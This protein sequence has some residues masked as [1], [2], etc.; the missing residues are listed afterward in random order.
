MKKRRVL[1]LWKAL[2]LVFS[3]LVG[4]AGVTVLSLYLMGNFNNEIIEPGSIEFVK[5]LS[6]GE[7]YYNDSLKQ[8]EVSSDFKMTITTPTENVTE[9][10]IM[11]SLKNNI[12]TKDGYISDGIIKVPQEVY[13]NKPFTVSLVKNDDV[14][15]EEWVV[16]GISTLT[17]KSTDVLSDSK[18]E[19][20][21]VDV[22]VSDINLFIG[23]TDTKEVVINDKFKID[24]QFMPESSKYLFSDNLRTQE[25][26]QQR[27]KEIFYDFTSSYIDYN[28]TEECFEAKTKSGNNF[29]EI[30][31]YTFSNSY[32]QTQIMQMFS[33]ITDREDLTQAVLE[34]FKTHE[35]ARVSKS[36][37]VQ[38]VDV[39]VSLVEMGE[40]GKTFNTYLDQYLTITTASTNGDKSL[41]LAIK[42]K[43][44]SSLPTLLA[45]VGIKI[46]Q[47]E[48]LNIS[49]GKIVEVVGDAITIK[50]FDKT[51][52]YF[53]APS[54]TEYYLLP[55][56]T[57]VSV[58]DY[59]WKLAAEKEQVFEF[60]V[61]LFCENKEGKLVKFFDGIAKQEPKFY[62]NA[63]MH[64]D[65][66]PPTWIN[67]NETLF[68]T[69]NYY[70]NGAPK[71]D[72]AELY[73]YLNAIKSSNIYQTVKYFL[74]VNESDVEA[75]FDIQTYFLCKNGVE[76]S[77]LTIS[78]A[79]A[80]GDGKYVLYEIED[81]ILSAK[82]SF[83]GK[84]KVIAAT[85]KT[86]A[87]KITPYIVDEKYVIVQSTNWAKEV[88]VESSLS[89]ANMEPTFAVTGIV[90]N[91]DGEYYIPAINR[92]EFGD[93]KTVITFGL[94]LNNCENLSVDQNKV[95]EAYD[96]GNLDIICVDKAGEEIADY[97]T[98]Q[99]LAVVEA[100]GQTVTL[101]GN[102]AIEE[103]YFSAGNNKVDEGI[104]ISLR[105]KY[106]DGN[107]VYPKA[108]VFEDDNTLDHLYVYYQQ[109]VSMKGEFEDPRY[110]DLD[111]DGDGVVDE[112]YVNMSSVGTQINWGNVTIPGTTLSEVLT[113]F[114]NYL[115]FELFDQ[116]GNLIE[117]D[118]VYKVKFVEIPVSPTNSNLLEFDPINK[119]SQILSTQGESKQT[120]LQVY[121]VEKKGDGEQETIV[122]KYD[123]EGNL[124]PEDLCSQI[125]TLNI[126][127][128]GLAKVQYNSNEDYLIKG[129]YGEED[130][131]EA[132][133]MS[134]IEVKK[135]VTSESEIDLNTLVKIYVSGAGNSQVLA[136]SVVFKLND[137]FVSKFNANERIDIM[138]MLNFKDSTGN[139]IECESIDEC[140]DKSISSIK[141]LNPFKVD[142]SLSFSITDEDEALFDITLTLWLLSDIA[143]VQSFSSYN[144]SMSEY[145][146]QQE[147]HESVFADESYNLDTYLGFTHKLANSTY[148]WLNTIGKIPTTNGYI[149]SS[150][151][152]LFYTENED[153]VKLKSDGTSVS[154]EILPVYQLKTITFTLYYG[155]HSSY[156]CSTTITLYVNPNIVVKK[157]L[158]T[159]STSY[160]NLNSVDLGNVTV[161][162][163]YSFYKLTSYIEK[164]GFD[165]A[166][167][168]ADGL[169]F[170]NISTSKYLQV[171]S[172][173]G[174]TNDDTFVF[175]QNS[176][177]SL[178]LGQTVEQ[179]FGIMTKGSTPQRVDAAMIIDKGTEKEIVLCTPG[180]FELTFNIGY[181]EG[182]LEDVASNILKRQIGAIE[183]E[184]EYEDVE[185][186]VYNGKVVLLL[187]SGEYYSTKYDADLTDD[188]AITENSE[189]G[190]LRRA[191]KYTLQAKGIIEFVSLSGNIF[192]VE[193][194]LTNANNITIIL[195]LEAIV[196]RIGENFVY[197]GPVEL[198]SG[199]DGKD[200][201]EQTDLPGNV[202][203]MN[204]NSFGDID[205][206]KLI[207]NYDLLE[208]NSV[209]QSLS[210]GQ[211]YNI[212]HI[213]QENF[214]EDLQTALTNKN[215]YGFYLAGG[216]LNNE[217]QQ[218]SYTLSVVEEAEGYVDGLVTVEKGGNDLDSKIKINHLESQYDEAYIVLKL[219]I[220]QYEAPTPFVWY[221]RIKVVSDFTVGKVSYP[222]SEDGE[223]LD[224]YS[225]YYNAQTESY[226]ID[227]EEELNVV[228]SKYETP[229]KRLADINWRDTAVAP[230]AT[231]KYK[232]KA[233]SAN[234]TSIDVAD[235][236][237]YIISSFDETNPNKLIIKPI[238]ILPMK[239]V[240][241]KTL[242]V[243]DVK[244]I[245][246]EMQYVLLFNQSSTYVVNLHQQIGNSDAEKIDDKNKDSIHE[247]EIQAGSEEVKF[248]TEIRVFSNDTYSPVND[249]NMYI[250]EVENGVAISELL[251]Y[252]HLIKKGV[253]YYSDISC[254][255]EAGE[256]DEDIIYG[257]WTESE[258]SGAIDIKDYIGD[259]STSYY[260]K[261]EDVSK[262]YAYSDE[263]ID[264]NKVLHIKPKTSI[265]QDGKLEIGYY[266]D[267]KR[268]FTIDL[269]VVS[270]FEWTQ[271]TEF[272]GG[273]DYKYKADEGGIFKNIQ[274]DSVLIGSLK[275]ELTNGD[276]VYDGTLTL[277][278]LVQISD[279]LTTWTDGT[280]K[281]AHLLKD[282]NFKFKATINQ[283]AGSEFS[284][285]FEILAKASFN[286]TTKTYDD[287]NARYGQ[288]AFNV[289]IS[290][291]EDKLKLTTAGTIDEYL[292]GEETTKS[293]TPNNVGSQEI[294]TEMLTI[295]Y[296][297][298]EITIFTFDVK[299]RYTVY[300]NVTITPNYP[301]P[302]NETKLSTEYISTTKADAGLSYQYVSSEFE[303]FFTSKAPFGNEKR[304]VVDDVDD[305]RTD[306]GTPV[307]ET[308]NIDVSS[309]S[310]AVVIVGNNAKT[311]DSKSSDLN[312]LKNATSGNVNLEFGLINT[313]TTG[314]VVFSIN[315][316]GVLATYSVVIVKD[317]NITI[318]TNAPNYQNN[319]ETVYA[320][321]LA[322]YP[323]KTLFKQDR[324]LNY[325]I[326]N[327]IADGISYWL[328]FVHS[329]SGDVK[330]FDITTGNA[331]LVTNIDLG[332]SYIGYKYE[333]TFT[334]KEKAED[335]KGKEDDFTLYLNAPKLT[336]RIMA[337]YYDG[338]PIVLDGDV[339]MFISGQKNSE[340]T[341]TSDDYQKEKSFNV[342]LKVDG[343]ELST[344]G[345]Y[346]IYLDVEFEVTGNADDK[347]GYTTVEIEAGTSKSL[348][349][350]ASLGIRNARTGLA[351][352]KESMEKSSGNINLSIYG[353]KE[354]QIDIL[355]TGTD[356][357][358]KTAG[359]IHNELKSTAGKDLSRD[360]VYS[361]GLTPS[362]GSG[363]TLNGTEYESWLAVNNYISLSGEKSP[364]DN[365]KTIDWSL[366]ANGA[367]NDGNY[368]MMRLTYTVEI[369]SAGNE[370]TLT[371]AHN[372]LFKVV[373]NSTVRFKNRH[374]EA[375]IT[376]ASGSEI[377]NGHTVA[378]NF[379]SPYEI[380]G[381][382]T[383]KSVNLWNSN[384]AVND[385][386]ASTIIA[387]MYG[388]TTN[389]A[390]RFKYTYTPNIAVG[391]N[392]LISILNSATNA[393]Y[394]TGWA[395]DGVLNEPMNSSTNLTLKV[396]ELSLGSRS[397]LVEAENEFGFKIRF[398]FRVTADANPFI[399]DTNGTDYKEGETIGIGARF[400]TVTVNSDGEYNA[401]YD[402]FEYIG[403][404]NAVDDIKINDGITPNGYT[405]EKAKLR[406]S[407][408]GDVF[409]KEISPVG[410]SIT[411]SDGIWTNV[412][413]NGSKSYDSSKL[414]SIILMLKIVSSEDPST[415]PDEVETYSATYNSNPLKQT[416]A[417]SS[418]YNSPD[419]VT[420]VVQG[421]STEEISP[422]HTVT[423][424]G[425]DAYGYSNSLI[426]VDT[427]S[428]QTSVVNDIKVKQVEF[429]YENDWLGGTYFTSNG[430]LTTNDSSSFGTGCSIT[431]YHK[432]LITDS[433]YSFIKG[434]T[435][436]SG[437]PYAETKGFVVPTIKGIYFGTGNR[438]PNVRMVIT[439][440][441][442]SNE[443]KIEQ[444]I[445]LTRAVETDNMFTNS[446]IMYDGDIPRATKTDVYDDTLEVVL[447]ERTVDGNGFENSS[448]TFAV[449][450]TAIGH[451]DAD[452][453]LIYVKTKDQDAVE[454]KNYYVKDGN[455]ME[456]QYPTQGQNPSTSE[457]YEVKAANLITK[458]NNR[459]YAVTEYVGISS[460]IVDLKDNLSVD[461][462][463]KFYVYVT[464]AIGGAKIKYFGNVI[465]ENSS[466]DGIQINGRAS[467]ALIQN[468]E[469]VDELD[470]SKK[471]VETLYFLYKY[472]DEYYQHAETFSIYPKYKNA[473]S[474][475]GTKI[476]I[477]DYI[478]VENNDDSTSKY[479]I[480][481]F[482]AWSGKL[483]FVNEG[484]EK[485]TPA[486]Y[487]LH[488]KIPTDGTGG[489]SAFIDENGTITTTEDFVIGTHYITFSIYMKV[490]GANGRFEENN[491]KLLLGTFQIYLDSGASLGTT[492]SDGTNP[493]RAQLDRNIINIP[494]G[495]KVTTN[496][497]FDS[498]GINFGTMYVSPNQTALQLSQTIDFD[499]TYGNANG[500]LQV[501]NLTNRAWHLVSYQKTTDLTETIP[502]TP[503]VGSWRPT[504]AGNYALTFILQGRDKD[505][506][507]IWYYYQVKTNLIVYETS[508][509]ETKSVDVKLGTT[510]SLG[511]GTPLLKKY[512]TTSCA[513]QSFERAFVQSSVKA[514]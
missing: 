27:T 400:K 274:S 172:S 486:Y 271:N 190:D 78:N 367:S 349:S 209:Y 513:I 388:E 37:Q 316:N 340:Y 38:V 141:V 69:I 174:T 204:F 52:D 85:I 365:N 473:T 306:A 301:M 147:P 4:L 338:T 257:D 292:F 332:M 465:G 353:F 478:K 142:T 256:L 259:K 471:K 173:G 144:D 97:I 491:E 372:I 207:G 202:D 223:Y 244:M 512:A 240:V 84:V 133:D 119:I 386:S 289:E 438:L 436:A 495:Y 243:D 136:N 159:N 331:G 273:Q 124:T 39:D 505:N 177:I 26:T 241:E 488:Y 464:E 270:Y 62:I 390:N 278:N 380:P 210:A 309:I 468:I 409:E 236:G 57:P 146:V 308:W 135:Y 262:I 275:I 411:I 123:S 383:G 72:N 484:G 149:E 293:I 93:P 23:G 348:L 510:Y 212:V 414:E 350:Y 113:N 268:V 151:T 284:F 115:T 28:W 91:G 107:S 459:S 352:T 68:M 192:K 247:T 111:K 430:I 185:I 272:S 408:D 99:G 423:L 432:D 433:A 131:T 219:E 374:E 155:V 138:E 307:V 65:E 245:G 417:V 425:I 346:N 419:F 220:A 88:V 385:I 183:G 51:I 237:D 265:K 80:S 9:T 454:G 137:G 401:V 106:N 31:V 5:E 53:N 387:N 49:G 381:A 103:E 109:P 435:P 361:T 261:A 8:F 228:N 511:S 150:D 122:K 322:A 160:I 226:E 407:I 406:A 298:N 218:A 299:Y 402:A 392:D 375:Q 336:S 89:I 191:N 32:Y 98:L 76:Y 369:G 117:N 283:G 416:H 421:Q 127:S 251:Q 61:N 333:G 230:T 140:A 455:V 443:A 44:N 382:G 25:T 324:I 439:V 263:N 506:A 48:G 426:A 311:I 508:T 514:L 157:D 490:S 458:S 451:V 30:T 389:K 130:Y 215:V 153:I 412:T 208:S 11:L 267:E 40:M 318:V 370:Q 391:Y 252:K 319:R 139:K 429:Y 434:G 75:G 200:Y 344:N 286:T 56:T 29:D 437:V 397:Y 441:S 129:S 224:N 477:D 134:K 310:N 376:N 337:H 499:E 148:S 41:E 323:E 125:L 354:N 379:A 339:E 481:P 178:L 19:K 18:T 343:K 404:S 64:D 405:I 181:G 453:G 329:T 328:R 345:T 470:S 120:Q 442:G 58:Y 50:G 254:T 290:E 485:M 54:G 496:M 297:F 445:T 165:D 424:G 239:V 431:D 213:L 335:N 287:T 291:L 199:V 269:S 95:L 248:E 94:V 366:Y 60:S 82:K 334:S 175:E 86:K 296:K 395:D 428:V 294:A 418:A 500:G 264:R 10:K 90:A 302:D 457:Y 255:A 250:S 373:P 403:S 266:T 480:I 235:F 184:Y 281:F 446:T 427:N 187:E 351:Y 463:D 356:D 167:V 81:G 154:L 497:E 393:T 304:I 145:L 179:R 83:T 16:G 231:S 24:T 33:Y 469:H 358:R 55:D 357:L 203:N 384:S 501:K 410:N 116:F 195:E 315:V 326:N 487:E 347:D 118:E 102:L 452:A 45:N 67:N 63:E 70:E 450:D 15:S 461:D 169:A 35:E 42:D 92:N 399:Y 7:G 59:N 327:S 182:N 104:Y 300:P 128:E 77:G 489:G 34:Y 186:A 234:D 249:Y 415:T 205:F 476:K 342:S 47:V 253:K 482:A 448:I 280:I 126:Q 305:A 368:V 285:N 277:A 260:V 493:Y 216:A 71:T 420:E 112:I 396:G 21:A 440:V 43:N 163:I 502:T 17:A 87:D 492:L 206:S 359:L 164:N 341:M 233:I 227:F 232:I 246:S 152:G 180:D 314:N 472:G 188:F 474:D 313:A 320:E 422:N 211:T 362:I 355:G 494:K 214:E 79:Q 1:S 258:P 282:V 317:S 22:P 66:Q 14:L 503:I 456:S 171:K 504:E 460:S 276:D 483:E 507:D 168:I 156:A 198:K 46:P 363:F 114:N 143:I 222:Y 193:K 498:V 100:E 225:K 447:P 36:I 96:T 176:S 279:N 121:V 229:T 479:Y 467:N 462:G 360:I 110:V 158:T 238:S 217:S 398:Y 194:M 189:T 166:D 162:D 288:K 449:A 475:E 108:V 394:P 321:D 242:Y 325:T 197:Y 13:L 73:E 221:Y 295:S 101:K 170:A 371:K 20:I 105:L 201:Y 330:V 413:P 132:T 466:T 444:Y 364:I 3:G 378:S 12:E 2:V 312:V 509:H 161:S 6:E 196:S 74:L 303:N 377:I